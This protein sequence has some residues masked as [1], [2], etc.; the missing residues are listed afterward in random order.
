LRFDTLRVDRV[1]VV[2]DV[3][4]D[5]RCDDDDV[6]EGREKKCKV[7]FVALPRSKFLREVVLGGSR[8]LIKSYLDSRFEATLFSLEG[9]ESVVGRVGSRV[10]VG[11]GPEQED[12]GVVGEVRTASSH[13]RF[14]R[15]VIFLC[16]EC[17]GS[18]FEMRR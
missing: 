15:G 9:G 18:L 10:E 1:P 14:E 6:L 16:G 7:S 11:S 12:A 2:D 5:G 8:G 4:D 13:Q 17:V 3:L